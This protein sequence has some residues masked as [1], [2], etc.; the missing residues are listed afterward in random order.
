MAFYSLVM[1][2]MAEGRRRLEVRERGLS[3]SPYGYIPW[4]RIISYTLGD[5]TL[6]LRLR[7]WFGPSPW[8]SQVELRCSPEQREALRHLLSQYVP[9]TPADTFERQ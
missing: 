9:E 2:H 4:K 1:A 8:P 6:T 5:T 7:S 3:L